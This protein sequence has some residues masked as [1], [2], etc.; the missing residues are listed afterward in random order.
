MTIEEINELIANI[1]KELI[2]PNTKNFQDREDFFNWITRKINALCTESVIPNAVAERIY[3]LVTFFESQ[4]DS[5]LKD[6]MDFIRA[7]RGATEKLNKTLNENPQECDEK[8]VKKQVGKK[9]EDEF[10]KKEGIAP[11]NQRSDG[12]QKVQSQKMG[13]LCDRVSRAIDEILR[14][15]DGSVNIDIHSYI[16]G[17]LKEVD[18]EMQEFTR[19]QNAFCQVM[20]DSCDKLLNVENEDKDER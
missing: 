20:L 4:K 11:K 3:T 10:R 1:D 9:V 15:I 5:M 2:E 13:E 18:N 17:R 19:D 6:D 8:V 7:F 12:H 16:H 14:D